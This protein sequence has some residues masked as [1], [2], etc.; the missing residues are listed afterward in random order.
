M[1]DAIY[2]G[3]AGMIAYSRGLDVISNNV[4]NLNTP[5]FK[6]TMSQYS[7]IERQAGDAGLPEGSMSGAG[8]AFDG[9]RLSFS[10]GQLQN[11]GNALDAAIDGQGFFILDQNGQR[12]YSR[13]GHFQFDKDGYLVDSVTQAR[14]MVKTD[15]SALQ[16]FDIDSYRSYTPKATTTITLSGSLARTST[17]SPNV[18]TVPSIS[19]IDTGGGT[20]V[21]SATFTQDA[22][23]PTKWT[24]E[25]F[26]SKNNSLGTG[27]IQF[28]A[29]GTPAA[30][31]AALTFVVKP[32][33]LPT[34]T[35]ALDIGKSGSYA[36]ITSVEGSTTST[37]QM[38][39]QDGVQL[40]SLT[41]AS[42]D[43]NGR[44][45]LTYSNG[46]KLYPATLLLANF[47][48]PGVLKEVGNSMF[49]AS[50]GQQQTVSTPSQNG[51]GQ[52]KGGQVEMSNVD[53][54]QQFTD[55]IVVQRGYQASSQTMSVANEMLQQ[56]LSMQS[57]H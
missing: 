45:Q 3:L 4:A 24:V 2:N 26:D 50:N 56:L 34:Y 12:Y 6:S 37:V 28:G 41:D 32:E 23:D 44:L 31:Q 55:L 43:A 1:L 16:P 21:L 57:G 48:D 35:V 38:L 20:Q 22:T 11:T 27:T 17:A 9:T 46:E 49:T 13:A 52:I 47:E 14:V 33:N 39:R 19:T 40:G 29:D 15:T 36:G 51:L 7:D 25:L 5:G 53:L 8:V 30:D 54:T 18:Y 42:F 10:E